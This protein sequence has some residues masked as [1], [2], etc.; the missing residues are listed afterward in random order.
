MKARLFLLC[1]FSLL[2]L[3]GCHV[4][5]FFWWNFADHDDFKKFQNAEVKA[6][7]SSK[8]F[9]FHPRTADTTLQL[10]RSITIQGEEIPFEEYI[11]KD[12][13]LAFLIIRNDS[14]LYEKYFRKQDETSLFTSF[15]VA[16]SFVSSLVGIAIAEGHIKSVH[17][18]ITRYL[19]ELDKSFDEVTLEHLLNMRS[20]ITFNEGYF[21]PFGHVAKFYYG[22]N[23][24][25]YVGKLEAGG[26]PNAAFEYRSG[27]TQLLAMA[28]ER[29]TGKALTEYLSEKIWQPLGMQSD[30]SWSMDSKKRQQAKAFCCLNAIARDYARFGRLYL[31]GGEWQG[32]Q[33]VPKAWVEKS[34][35]SL[36]SNAFMYAYQWWHNNKVLK[37]SP[38][39]TLQ[40]PHWVLR[41]NSEGKPERVAFPQDDFY[42]R[43]ILGQ[44]IYVHPPSNTLILRFGET[45]KDVN[46]PRFFRQV[47]LAIAPKDKK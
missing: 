11:Q 44:Y 14:V 17:D 13:T 33:I 31:H 23:L 29:V 46:W 1:L 22:R 3:S 7:P 18:P 24:K 28:V 39:T 25:K 41:K 42:A 9:Q 45:D 27:N 6:K 8:A 38:D 20:G 26:E 37:V 2:L 43:G 34:R 12:K 4:G 10:P 35:H 19:P 36:D 5:R 32:Q 30:A 40:I 21:N 15:S 16:K 47:T